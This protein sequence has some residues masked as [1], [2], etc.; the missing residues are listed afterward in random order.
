[1]W[2]RLTSLPRNYHFLKW[3]TIV[4]GAIGIPWGTYVGFQL[5]LGNYLVAVLGTGL[6]IVIYVVDTHIWWRCYELVGRGD[7]AKTK[8][9]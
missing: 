2:T 6:E 3:A 5:C 1:M 7:H 4:L 9:D 8:V